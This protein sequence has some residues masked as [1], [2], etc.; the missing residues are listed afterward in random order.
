MGLPFGLCGN[1]TKQYNT[2]P[3]EPKNQESA[4]E[5]DTSDK[6]LAHGAAQRVGELDLSWAE[7]GGC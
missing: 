7:A 1:K 2:E 6:E 4:G 3:A 5:G